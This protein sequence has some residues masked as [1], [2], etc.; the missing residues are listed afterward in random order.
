[1]LE[2]IYPVSVSQHNL[3]AS[4]KRY[5]GLMLTKL[6]KD[7]SFANDAGQEYQHHQQNSIMSVLTSCEDISGYHNQNEVLDID[8]ILGYFG[9]P[10]ILAYIQIT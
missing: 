2:C 5:A 6:F 7:I 8:E 3:N 10:Q 4:P 9:V 1:M